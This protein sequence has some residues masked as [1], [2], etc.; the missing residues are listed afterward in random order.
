MDTVIHFQGAALWRWL[1]MA[2]LFWPLELV[3]YGISRLSAGISM[4]LIY[5]K[6]VRGSVS[7][8]ALT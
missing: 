8:Y 4:M 3:A 7:S 6:L 5:T 1:L 2:L